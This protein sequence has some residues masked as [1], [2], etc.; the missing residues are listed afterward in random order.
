MK[1]TKSNKEFLIETMDSLI[2]LLNNHGVYDWSKVIQRHRKLIERGGSGK[3]FLKV[4]SG[5]MG[6]FND[7]IISR[8]N[9]H[10]INQE[11]EE[12]VNRKLQKLS[13]KAYK[14]AMHV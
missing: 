6:S 14:I 4:F 1:S 5:G 13:D 12:T 10:R 2:M 7:L 11:D 9:R 3:E 8:G